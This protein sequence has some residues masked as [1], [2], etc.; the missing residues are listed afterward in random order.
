MNKYRSAALVL[1]ACAVGLS[2]AACSSGSSSTTQFSRHES[3]CLE[4]G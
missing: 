4:P 2:A 3:G 1:A